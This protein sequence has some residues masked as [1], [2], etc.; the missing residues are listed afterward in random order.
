MN[1][2]ACRSLVID[3]VLCGNE[4]GGIFSTRKRKREE[5]NETVKEE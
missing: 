1:E 4:G 5:K 3:C 2:S